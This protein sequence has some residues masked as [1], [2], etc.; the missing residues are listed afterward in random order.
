M[1]LEVDQKRI[2]QF[3]PKPKLGPLMC[4]ETEAE[5]ESERQIRPNPKL[6][7]HLY[8]RLRLATL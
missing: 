8:W 6:K 5:T 1:H 4:T 7:L 3:R 2:F